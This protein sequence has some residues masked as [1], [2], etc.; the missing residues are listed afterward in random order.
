MKVRYQARVD[1]KLLREMFGLSK[2][3]VADTIYYSIRTLERMEKEN[4]VT[5]ESTARRLCDLYDIKYEESFFKYNKNTEVTKCLA[6]CGKPVKNLVEE[7]EEY[8]LLY[9]RKTSI[10]KSCIAGKVMWVGFTDD[11]KEIR[12]LRS[13]NI[14]ALLENKPKI[15]II[16]NYDEWEFWYLNLIIGKLYQV[17]VSKKCMERCLKYCLRNIIVSERE[18]MTYDETTDIAFLGMG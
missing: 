3:E 6:Q 7:T 8:Y 15:L 16:N 4:A 17:I 2:E 14:S 10:V 18:L 5:T 1:L 9:V 12:V 11:H 13:I